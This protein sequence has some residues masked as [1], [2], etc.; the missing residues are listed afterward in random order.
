MEHIKE[1][2]S[3]HIVNN[4]LIIKTYTIGYKPL[5]E[6]IVI[7]VL[8][9]KIVKFSAVID[10]FE[11]EERNI[12]LDILNENNIEKVDL[13]CLTHPDKDHCKGLEKILDKYDNTTKILYSVNLFNDHD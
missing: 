10:C 13:I 6:S 5:G 1:F 8:A 12:T 4:E 11:N 3:H 7:L 2:E 9:D